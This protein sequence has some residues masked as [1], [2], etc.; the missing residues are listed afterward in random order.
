MLADVVR[1]EDGDEHQVE[2]EQRVRHQD[3]GADVPAFIAQVPTLRRTQVSWSLP[4]SKGARR[5][6]FIVGR[7][8]VGKLAG[9]APY[10]W[11]ERDAALAFAQMWLGGAGR[12]P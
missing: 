4:G 9:R 3:D 10:T 7:T 2:D 5:K 12:A 11:E 6:V 8:D 1:F